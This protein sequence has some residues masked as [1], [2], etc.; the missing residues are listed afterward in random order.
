MKKASVDDVGQQGWDIQT[1]YGRIN[2]KSAVQA[3]YD[4]SSTW[5][6]AINYP[7]PF[8][9][10][11]DPFTTISFATTSKPQSLSVYN[12]A[13]EL[14][15]SVPSNELTLSEIR[16]EI[17]EPQFVYRYEWNGKTEREASVAQGIYV[18]CIK[19]IDGKVKSGKIALIR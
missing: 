6:T 12:I 14:I 7:N 15:L 11:Q 5:I 1:G 19:S 18:Y 10:A 4:P 9:P 8:N 3:R 13:G 16:G 2:A 17:G